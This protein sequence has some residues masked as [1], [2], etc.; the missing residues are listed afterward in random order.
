VGWAL[1]LFAS[2]SVFL[3]AGCGPKASGVRNPE[4]VLKAYVAAVERGDL[5]RAYL[6]MSESYRKQHNKEDFVRMLTEQRRQARRT[7]ARLKASP[8]RVN[9][10]A[11]LSYGD[12]DSLR[13]VLDRGV[14]RIASDPLDFYSQRT[15]AEALRSFIRAI[16]RRRYDIVLRFVPNKW[17][18][19]MTIEKLKAQWE[20]SK[21]G[22]VETLLKNLKANLN[23]PI[24]RAGS[25]ASLAYGDRFEVRFVR[26]D[27][28]WKIED[29]D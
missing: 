5:D 16:E 19:S 29:P 25:T 2:A 1:T 6:L 13:L 14:W 7:L 21:R 15:P 10:E 17:A 24:H 27:G 28:I 22:E 9:V 18:E 11:R 26:E 4:Q 3:G 20:G 12:N 23:A 8:Q